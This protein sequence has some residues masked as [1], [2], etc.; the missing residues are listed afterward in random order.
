MRLAS[1][2]D[3][4]KFFATSLSEP[5]ETR[6]ARKVLHDSL[7]GLIADGSVQK[8]IVIDDCGNASVSCGPTPR[9]ES[10]DRPQA[11]ARM[12][13]SECRRNRRPRRLSSGWLTRPIEHLTSMASFCLWLAPG[14]TMPSAD[15]VS[16]SFETNGDDMAQADFGSL[17]AATTP[18]MVK[19][20]Q[21]SPRASL[22]LSGGGY[23]AMVFHCRALRRLHEVGALAKIDRISSVSGGSIAKPTGAWTTQ[24]ACNL[25]LRHSDK[26]GGSR[27]LVRDRG[28]QF[29][30]SFDVGSDIGGPGRTPRHDS[31]SSVTGSTS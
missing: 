23:R 29:T 25:F 28:S 5:I 6:T 16:Q 17:F 10:S 8:V 27:A 12:V 31:A 11:A 26:L 15:D 14:W 24:A 3:I 18:P 13:G 22:A 19:A 2:D 9:A 21:R 1:G 20:T 4:S 30:E 7:D